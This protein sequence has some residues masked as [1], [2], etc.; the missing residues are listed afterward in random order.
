[1][2]NVR[3]VKEIPYEVDETCQIA[4]YHPVPRWNAT[5]LALRNS[6]LN[7]SLMLSM[8]LTD[9]VQSHHLWVVQDDVHQSCLLGVRELDFFSEDLIG[10]RVHQH[11]VFFDCSDKL[12]DHQLLGL[13]GF[14][15][16]EIGC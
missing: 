11:R 7:P 12:G 16:L 5:V 13:L 2:V 14:G 1:M 15:I 9:L 8:L 4:T 3:L 10:Q 6:N